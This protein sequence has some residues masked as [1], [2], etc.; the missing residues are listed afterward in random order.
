MS[1]VVAIVLAGGKGKRMNS[2]IAKQYMLIGD[3]PVLYYTIKAFEESNVDEIVVVADDIEYC[4]N[5]IV[6]QYGFRKV[7][8]LVTGGKERYDSVSN[9]L[10][11]IYS[12]DYVLIHDGARPCIKPEVINKSIDCVKEDKAVVVAVPVKD[13]IKVVKEGVIDH[14]PN[15]SLLWSVQTPQCFEFGL[16]K[17][18]YDLLKETPNKLI[19]DDAMVLEEMTGRKASVLMGD[20]TNIKVTTPEDIEIAKM[21]IV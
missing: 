6:N 19:T 18:A 8:H 14:T 12:A 16:I 9:G 11:S 20:Y 5:H 17:N 4:K 10:D 15:R 3:K 21:F 13:T 2:D 1:K 7:S